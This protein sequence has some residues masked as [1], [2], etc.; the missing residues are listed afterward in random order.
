MPSLSRGAAPWARS[1]ESVRLY[2]S[3]GEDLSPA[4]DFMNFVDTFLLI[5][6]PKKTKLFM[7]SDYTTPERA[8]VFSAV[9]ERLKKRLK[10]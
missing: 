3:N 10:R 5:K 1:R 9:M 6:R 2:D 8:E 4:Y 7:C